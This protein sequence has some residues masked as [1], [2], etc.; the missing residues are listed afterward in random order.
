MYFYCSVDL[1]SDYPRLNF[2][3]LLYRYEG[4][5]C[6]WDPAQQEAAD[7]PCYPACEDDPENWRYSHTRRNAL[8]SPRKPNLTSNGLQSPVTNFY[9]VLALLLLMWYCTPRGHSMPFVSFYLGMYSNAY[10]IPSALSNNKK[11]SQLQVFKSIEKVVTG[12]SRGYDYIENFLKWN[13]KS[14][15]G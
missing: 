11:I 5:A 1:M 13:D 6:H 15:V 3:I 2:F 9:Q 14:V 4:T 10:L 8:R 7:P 12:F